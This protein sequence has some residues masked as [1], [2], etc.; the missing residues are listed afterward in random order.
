MSAAVD[1]FLREG[2]HDAVASCVG[3]ES[4]HGQGTLHCARVVD[5]GA[6]VVNVSEVLT[7][8]VGTEPVV[9]GSDFFA[10]EGLLCLR[11]VGDRRQRAENDSNMV[12]LSEFD[13]GPDVGGGLPEFV[14]T[15]SKDDVVGP[16]ED[17]DCGR[18]EVD[19]VLLE[20]PQH[21][22][23]PLPCHATADVGFSGKE[24]CCVG[25]GPNVCDGAAVEDD[26]AWNI[27][28][29]QLVLGLVALQLIEV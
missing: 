2:F 16:S 12:A 4:V 10:E 24:L 6:V 7:C 25:S 23:C 21:L 17:D 1:G 13:H 26:A 8:S 18:V 15:V 9:D 14:V 29:E 28:R 5:H 3:V 20:S 11:I 19:D 27:W 22:V